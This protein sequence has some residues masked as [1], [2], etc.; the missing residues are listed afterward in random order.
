MALGMWATGAGTGAAYAASQARSE[1]P[2]IRLVAVHAIF[3]HGAR[4]P[5]YTQIPGLSDVQWPPC[6]VGGAEAF[7]LEL[8]ASEP[9]LRIGGASVAPCAV[10]LHHL[11]DES[12][13]APSAPAEI[14]SQWSSALGGGC[15]GGQ[16]TDLG[17]AQA[18]ELGTRLREAYAGRLVGDAW[19]P[20]AMTARST[21]VPRCVAS[22]Q[23]A[24]RGLF[25]EQRQPVPVAV[26]EFGE[27]TLF[28]NGRLSERLAH[29]LAAGRES[30]QRA[31]SAEAVRTREQL[32]ATM[33]SDVFDAYGM[34][35]FN[36]VRCAH[37]APALRARAARLCS[38]R[39][40]PAPPRGAGCATCWWPSRRTACRCRT[41]WTRTACPSGSTR[42]PPSR[43]CA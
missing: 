4:T 22:A 2:A 19:D 3:R 23:F 40:P 34:D 42:S 39:P 35:K 43:S 37:G 26:G 14:L 38:R 5:V 36:Y 7:A 10:R 12:L 28:P 8:P 29:I 6:S 21:C 18:H 15:R 24:L 25:P 31:P 1:E 20:S 30:W 33:P 32:A 13:P 9:G 16:L 41:A 27:E 11:S 17:C